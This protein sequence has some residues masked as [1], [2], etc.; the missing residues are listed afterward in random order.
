MRS[1]IIRGHGEILPETFVLKNGQYVVF[2]QR[3][4]DIAILSTTNN[5]HVKNTLRDPNKIYR[6]IKGDFNK[7][8]FPPAFRNPIILGPGNHVRNMMIRM[9]DPRPMVHERMGIF[10]AQKNNGTKRWYTTANKWYL[11]GRGKTMKLSSKKAIGNSKG[12]FFVNSCR[13]NPNYENLN[14]YGKRTLEG[15]PTGIPK[16]KNNLKTH[17]YETFK[18]KRFQAKRKYPHEN[19][20]L[21]RSP[22]HR[23]LKRLR[24]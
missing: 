17:M 19:V 23:A 16:T 21:K 9:N 1:Y 15:K 11:R 20:K 22:I 18:T 24:I 10:N 7:S 4:G 5:S 14:I 13:V 8:K 3:C 6:F 12:M 2:A